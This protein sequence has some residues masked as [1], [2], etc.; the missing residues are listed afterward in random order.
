MAAT[1]TALELTTATN[2]AEL[3]ALADGWDELVLAAPR[4]SPF[5]LHAWLLEWWR[6]YG[7]GAE[8]AVHVAHRDG[9]LVAALPLCTRR[10]NGL[11]I[12]EFIGGRASALAD[13][14]LA[15]GESEAT[16]RA[17]VERAE[18]DRRDLA[19]LF[20][21]PAESR[22]V[23]A[24]PPGRLRLI[25][26]IE[27]PVL[28]LSGGWEAVYRAKTDSKRRNLHKRRRRQLAEQGRELRVEL[29]RSPE[30]L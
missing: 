14:L 7:E 5:L 25:E 24:A 29:A 28:D 12:T 1:A 21:L 15:D 4:P 22:L 18:S 19:D 3:A 20:G 9:R 2:E 27:A 23:A 13:L 11:R 30:E 26:R 6:E 17:L 16:A 10:R 8:L